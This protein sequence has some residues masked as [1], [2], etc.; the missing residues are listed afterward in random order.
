MLLVAVP[1]PFPCKQTQNNSTN[2]L[3]C[4]CLAKPALR[5]VDLSSWFL[6]CFMWVF[7][8]T[9]AFLTHCSVHS[10][11]PQS[12]P[13]NQ[14]DPLKQLFFMMALYWYYLVRDRTRTCCKPPLMQHL[15]GFP[16]AAGSTVIRV[17]S[18]MTKP[19]YWSIR[20]DGHI[21]PSSFPVNQSAAF[22]IDWHASKTLPPPEDITLQCSTR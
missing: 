3:R 9:A 19:Q 5:K 4:S 12:R 6:C 21:A 17:H 18:R 20:L 10:N 1:G 15:R 14:T 13:Y 11:P 2:K 22:P 16:G 8:F 7:Q